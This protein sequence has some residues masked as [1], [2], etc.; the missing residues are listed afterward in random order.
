MK[1]MHVLVTSLQ[2]PAHFPL[3]GN[4]R[5]LSFKIRRLKSSSEKYPFKISYISLPANPGMI[6]LHK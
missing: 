5:K 2:E 1:I 4:T 6:E 3:R